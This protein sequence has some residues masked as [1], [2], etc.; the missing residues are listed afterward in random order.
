M[1]SGH[2]SK[3]AFGTGG[4]FG[5][6]SAR[7]ASD[8][9]GFASSIRINTFDTG[10]AYSKGRSQSLLYASLFSLDLARQSYSVCSKISVRCLLDCDKTEVIFKLFSG[11]KEHINYIDTLML[12][13]LHWRS[14]EIRM[15][16]KCFAIS[17]A[18]GLYGE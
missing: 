15:L 12:W 10:L 1:P 3:I 5:R 11:F 4:R 17:V 13:G 6:L 18:M 2:L 9:V 16:L 8:L 7:E 14:C